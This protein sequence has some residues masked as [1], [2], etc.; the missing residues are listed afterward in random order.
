MKSIISDEQLCNLDWEQIDA[1]Q[2]TD[3]LTGSVVLEVIPMTD[4]F[5]DEN[6]ENFHEA[7]IG[8]Q[9]F[10][11]TQNGEHI[12]VEVVIDGAD[13]SLPVAPEASL[14]IRRAVF[15]PEL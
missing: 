15:V 3:I 13:E 11:R 14:V 7:M 8:H 4:G 12:A 5:T 1:D 10:L 9:Y 2:F 6:G